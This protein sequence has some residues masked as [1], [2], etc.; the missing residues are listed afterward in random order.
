MHIRAAP[1]VLAL[2]LAALAGAAGTAP[3]A[4]LDDDVLA[5]A[6]SALGGDSA[7]TDSGNIASAVFSMPTQIFGDVVSTSQGRR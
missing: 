3:A 4:D 2:T 1:A 6:S 7:T 5:G